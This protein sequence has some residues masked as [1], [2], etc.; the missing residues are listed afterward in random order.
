MIPILFESG[1]ISIQT[2]WVF[3]VIALLLSSYLAVKRLKRRRVTMTLFIEHSGSFLIAATLVSRIV[4]FF[5]HRTTY[6]PRFDLR[7]LWNFIA[8]WDQGFSFWGAVLGFMAM[9]TYRIWKEKEKLWKWY[10]ALTIP[11]LV[12][13]MIGYF[14]A[15]LGGY[16]YGQPSTLPWAVRY[17]SINVVYTVP[18]HPTQIYAILLIGLLLFSKK[19]IAEKSSFFRIDGNAT[20]FFTT[21]LS[22]IL[23]ALEFLRGDDTLM[24]LSLRLPMILAFLVTL[25]A[26]Y[27]LLKRIISFKKNHEN[28]SI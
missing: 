10:D 16:A 12:G 17:E 23:F 27:P 4:Y 3:V 7:T 15:F 2:L 5:S 14:G 20:L 26:G 24:V 19:K 11:F 8:I 25:A 22:L 28:Q 21:G 6:F 13:L 18:I 9:L 1:P